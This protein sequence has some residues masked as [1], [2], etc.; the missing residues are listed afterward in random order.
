MIDVD[1]EP[2]ADTESKTKND[3]VVMEKADGEDDDVTDDVVRRSR[4]SRD[5]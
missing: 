5:D 2:E 1:D 3:D 4:A